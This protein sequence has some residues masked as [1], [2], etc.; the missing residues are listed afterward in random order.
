MLEKLSAEK[1]VMEKDL[2]MAIAEQKKMSAETQNDQVMTE[3]EADKMVTE[4]QKMVI[5]AKTD[6][7]SANV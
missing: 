5:D 6:L 4:A 2:A 1:N 3:N 7:Q